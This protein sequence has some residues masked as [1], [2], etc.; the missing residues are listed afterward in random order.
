MRSMN[1]M[2]LLPVMLLAS[3][4]ALAADATIS[5]GSR[6]TGNQEQ[7]KVLYIVPWQSPGSAD[8]LK[9]PLSSQV[10]TVFAHVERAELVRELKYI[11]TVKASKK[12]ISEP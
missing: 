1:I 7:P 12:A 6:V 4:G 5:I 11:E 10:N 2:L 8:S 9:Q 3:V